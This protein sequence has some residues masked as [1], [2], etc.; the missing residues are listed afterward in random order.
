MKEIEGFIGWRAER[1]LGAGLCIFQFVSLR[2]WIVNIML[3]KI[4][5]SCFYQSVF[6]VYIQLCFSC[7][8]V[9]SL[10][11]GFL[12]RWR[13]CFHLS[14][15][16]WFI[17]QTFF[18]FFLSG[19]NLYDLWIP[20]AVEDLLSSCPSFIIHPSDIF[21]FSSCLDVISLIYGFLRQWR[22]CFHLAHLSWFII[23]THYVFLLL[24]T[25]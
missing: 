13:I 4:P 15:L 2:A 20:E 3:L 14:H 24:I 22:I 18:F 17:A 12:R 19:C 21:Y 10:I 9:I 8:D 5:L 6:L 16:S 25:T 11:Y 23:Q 7:M 1:V